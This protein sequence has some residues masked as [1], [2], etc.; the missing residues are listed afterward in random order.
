MAELTID[1]TRCTTALQFLDK[2]GKIIGTPIGNFSIL[3][4]YLLN[5]HYSKI[6]FMGMTV[7][8]AHCPHA[9]KEMEIMMDRVKWH[10]QKE[11]KGFE[12][13]LKP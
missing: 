13:E 4:Q 11:G 3:S 5:N 9:A 2:V 1:I 6:T 7:F 12:Y 8:R 10:F